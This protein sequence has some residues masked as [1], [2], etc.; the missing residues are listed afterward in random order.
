MGKINKAS[1]LLRDQRAYRASWTLPIRVLRYLSFV[2]TRRP[3]AF[4]YTALRPNYTHY[5]EADSD[6]VNNMDS[7]EAI[8]WHVS[9]GDT[10]L[11]SDNLFKQLLASGPILIR[12]DK[13][14]SPTS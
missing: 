9:R 13:T 3:T 7:Y 2:V 8:L 4:R 10:C 5:W 12:V 11:N 1:I 14:G 6:A